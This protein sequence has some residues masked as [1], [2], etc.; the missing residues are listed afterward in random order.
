M[1]KM[2]KENGG[3]DNI[4]K[5]DDVL[6]VRMF[7]EFSISF[8]ERRIV[9]NY[10][11]SKV[12]NLMGYLLCRRDRKVPQEDLIHILDSEKNTNPLTALRNNIRRLRKTLAELE[13]PES[14]E[15]ILT[16]EGTYG[17]NSELPIY[18]DAEKFEEGCRRALAEKDEE[19]KREA[20]R[21]TL[22]LFQGPFLEKL[23]GEM[24]LNEV[25]EHYHSLF[26]NA[27]EQAVPLLQAAGYGE[28]AAGYLRM[29][30]RFYP[31]DE[32]LCRSLMLCLMDSANYQGA[33]IVYAELK[34]R[35]HTDLGSLPEP[36]TE[37]I[38]HQIL[39]RMRPQSMTLD[40]IRKELVPEEV[41]VGAFICNYDIFRLLYQSEER[42]SFR[43]GR[44]VHIGVLTVEGKD[45][46]EISERV[47]F[48]AMENLRIVL[49]NSLRRVD[50]AARC[51]Q[52][53]YV[54]MLKEISLEDTSRV[55]RRVTTTFELDYPSGTVRIRSDVLL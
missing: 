42:S 54:L 40:A 22:P 46:K 5:G 11:G 31:Y 36:Q 44:Y 20:L 1:E 14:Y 25:A 49:Q 53:Q 10:S 17:W 7:G 50:V 2:R 18:I 16:G 15:P 32:E 41:P 12:W 8:G 30:L 28:E 38:R 23:S 21:K 26:R 29:A 37:A 6:T 45:G 35:L 19:K 47:L 51:S 43:K 9:D 52:S 34:E 4:V 27:T 33:E 13:L 55:L 39:R 24:W 3:Q 48:N